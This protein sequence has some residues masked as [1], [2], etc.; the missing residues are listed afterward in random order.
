MESNAGITMK[1]AMQKIVALSV[2]EAELFAA[3]QCAQDMLFVM[4]ILKSMQLQ[5]E[6]PMILEVDNKGAVDIANNWSVSGR[7]KHI[8]TKQYFLRQMKEGIIKVIWIPGVNNDSDI[9]TKNLPGVDFRKHAKIFCGN[10]K[11]MKAN[12]KGGVKITS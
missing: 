4:R 9:F 5:V 11:Y 1:S 7:T 2:T 12:E 6:L 8:D 3:V 10:D